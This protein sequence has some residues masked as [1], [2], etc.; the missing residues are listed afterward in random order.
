MER[1]LPALLWPPLLPVLPRPAPHTARLV[2]AKL[3]RY[4]MQPM[5]V[6][7]LWFGLAVNRLDDL[8]KCA[9]TLRT[10]TLLHLLL[11]T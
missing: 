6:A 11:C 9:V 4:V 5:D 1:P 8:Y 7:E 3:L 2:A 10:A